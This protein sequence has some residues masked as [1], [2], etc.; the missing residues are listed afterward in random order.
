MQSPMI[1]TL[2]LLPLVQVPQADPLES[3]K[4]AF[5]DHDRHRFASYL[6]QKC[7]IQIDL[8]PLLPEQGVISP[9]Q[10]L[11]C[12]ERLQHTYRT[13]EVQIV[14]QTGDTNYSRLECV[15]LLGLVDQSGTSFKAVFRM[16]FLVGD[17][18]FVLSHWQLTKIE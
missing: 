14:D 11:L 5:E 10:A 6:D 2:L 9:S 13:S 15:M 16:G 3:L 4:L 7:D 17:R 1:I 12:F 8:N 18:D